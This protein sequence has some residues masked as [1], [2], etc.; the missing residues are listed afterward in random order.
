NRPKSQEV[1]PIRRSRAPLP[2]RRSTRCSHPLET[3]ED[4][5][6]TELELVHAVVPSQDD[7]LRHPV[8]IRELLDRGPMEELLRR[9][10]VLG[11]VE[12]EVQLLEREAVDVRVERGPRM[13][14]HRVREARLT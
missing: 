5:L 6:E 12:R 7:L 9:P 14:C 3:V 13:V 2:V 8:Q 4:Q 1:Q 11:R 10:G